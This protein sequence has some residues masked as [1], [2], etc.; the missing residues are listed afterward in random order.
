M[1]CKFPSCINNHQDLFQE[2]MLFKIWHI[3]KIFI[4]KIIHC[5]IN[6]IN[7]T[8]IKIFGLMLKYFIQ[9]NYENK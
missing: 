7:I 3:F 1:L 5:K 8:G 6:I 9:T 4:S 2:D